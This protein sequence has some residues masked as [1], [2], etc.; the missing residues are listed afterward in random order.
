MKKYLAAVA[1]AAALAQPAS[2]TTFS[3]LIT[4]YVGAGV[5]SSSEGSQSW[6]TIVHCSNV[7]GVP[8]NLRFVF[9]YSHGQLATTHT[10]NNI[11]H[12]RTYSVATG[13]T[14]FIP[15]HVLSSLTL[16][17]GVVNIESTESGVFC[18]AKILDSDDVDLVGL[19][20]PLV[21]V[22]PHPGTV[23]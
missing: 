12:G 19:N 11:V 5:A 23:E 3:K 17:E 1:L 14:P 21:R 18:V 2:A 9:L 6:A 22:N 4:I 15:S 20:L 10:A 16:Q 13:T 8:V 7:S